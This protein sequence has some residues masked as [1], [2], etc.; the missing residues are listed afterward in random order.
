M[1]ADGAVNSV[2]VANN[3]ITNASIADGTITPAKLFITEVLTPGSIILHHTYNGAVS[4]PRGWLTCDGTLISQA[5]YESEHGT[6]SY[7]SDGISQSKL[8]NKYLPNFEGKYAVGS[9]ITAATGVTPIGVV[10]NIGNQVNLSHIHSIPSHRHQWI[11]QNDR[12]YAMNS[13]N[14]A[15]NSVSLNNGQPNTGTRIQLNSAG[16]GIGATGGVDVNYYTSVDGAGTTSDS[17]QT[18]KDIQPES[19]RV[20]YIMKIK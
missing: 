3:A 1:L 13:W 9:A 19:I 2:N 8:L 17:S 12:G 10:G 4:V 6:G 11:A 7:L 16:G 20:K 18:T 14:G 15:G 5:R